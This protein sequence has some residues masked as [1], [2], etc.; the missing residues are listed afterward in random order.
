MTRRA[1][2]RDLGASLSAT[3]RQSDL[4]GHQTSSRLLA[5]LPETAGADAELLIGRLLALVDPDLAADL[6]FGVA[7]F[8]SEE[9]TWIGLEQRAIERERT[10]GRPP[11]LDS[12]PLREPVADVERHTRELLGEMS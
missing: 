3:L 5:V 6:R 11:F 12:A 9:V 2:V 10:Q 1:I 7:C 8:P 4:I